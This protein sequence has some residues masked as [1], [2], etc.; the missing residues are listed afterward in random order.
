MSSITEVLQQANA[1]YQKGQLDLAGSLYETALDLEPDCFEARNRLGMVRL[2][3][4]LVES[5]IDQ[6]EHALIVNPASAEASCNLGNALATLKRFDEALACYDGAL[7]VCPQHW[8]ALNN[9]GNV[10]LALGRHDEAILSYGDAI[11]LGSAQA[12]PYFNRGLAHFALLHYA[13]SITDFDAAIERS[14]HHAEALQARGH[15]L[16][17][18]RRY[19]EA[20]ASYAE[21]VSRNPNLNYALGEAF[22]ARLQLCD[23]TDYDVA[24]QRLVDGVNAGQAV[25]VPFILFALS[26][27]PVAQL[28]CAATYA[29]RNHSVAPLPLAKHEHRGRSKIRVAYLSAKFREHAGAHL[30]AELL[31]LH[32]K[33]RFETV[34]ISFGPAVKDGMRARFE[35]C[36]DE[37]FDVRAFTDAD[38]C[39]LVREREVDIAIDLMGYQENARP[40][41]FAYRAAPVQVS[42]L[43]WTGTMGGSFMDYVIGDHVVIPSGDERYYSENV[44][45]LPESYQVNDSKKRISDRAPTRADVGLPQQ[46][47]VFCCF[48]NNFKITPAIFDVWMRLLKKVDGSVLW[49]LRATATAEGNLRREAQSR[50]VD[51]DRVV[52]APKLPLADH[53]ARHRLANLFLDTMPCNAHVTASDSLWTGL[54]VLTCMG[55]SFMSRV[56]GSLLNALDLP[57]LVTTNIGEY[58][59]RAIELATNPSLMQ[60]LT[61][62]VARNRT[63]APLFDTDRFRRHIEAAYATMW[64][65]HQRGEKPRGFAVQPIA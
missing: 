65:I 56:A 2:R 49:L 28:S 24:L 36:F 18:L 38:I 55:R 64:S 50:G 51:P 31:E 16:R 5:A 19:E 40:N 47:F 29:Q 61:Q 53:L 1:L 3:Q 62:K 14:P 46:G 43:S 9:R 35:A 10:L 60:E 34:G 7:A 6:F 22:N 37:F 45:R 25:T 58:E 44:V 57:E 39:E 11:E 48:N 63:V 8:G 23:W 52:F 30:V 42:F 33:R 59:A 27:D 54:P 26:D 4:G 20:A 32:D 17:A 15:S 12:A 41:I 13:E 21:A